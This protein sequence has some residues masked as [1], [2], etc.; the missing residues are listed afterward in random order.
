MDRLSYA[1]PPIPL[2]ERTLIKTRVD[3]AEEVIVITHICIGD[4][5]TISRGRAK[6][7]S[8]YHADRICRNACPCKG[9]LY[10]TNLET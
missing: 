1:Y 2:L 6:P 10:H 7:P 4:P 5:G 9:L 3:Q 8:C